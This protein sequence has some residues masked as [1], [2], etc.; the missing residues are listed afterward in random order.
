[1][2]KS[3]PCSV[4]IKQLKE[5]LRSNSLKITPTRLEVLDI[6]THTKKPVSINDLSMQLKDTDLATLYR[7][8]ETL[9]ELELVTQVDFQHG[10]AHYELATRKHHHHL[11]CQKCGKIVDISKCDTTLLEKQALKIAKFAKIS[12]HSL[13]FFGICKTCYKN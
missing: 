7:T 8:F 12:A 4:H 1:M 2:V 13:E 5:I 10:H 11:V 3:I 9:K 6:L